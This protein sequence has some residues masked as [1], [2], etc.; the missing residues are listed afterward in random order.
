MKVRARAG[1]SS[2]EKGRG[3]GEDY[4]GFHFESR[5]PIWS[6]FSTP[7]IPK[8]HGRRNIRNRRHPA[9]RSWSMFWHSEARQSSCTIFHVGRMPFTSYFAKRRSLFLA[10]SCSMSALYLFVC[11]FVGIPARA[12]ERREKRKLRMGNH[13]TAGPQ[14]YC[15]YDTWMYAI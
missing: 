5:D 6:A 7:E 2:K 13:R 11:T 14:D 8:G 10:Y 1:S 4:H 12:K 3:R 15:L 9:L